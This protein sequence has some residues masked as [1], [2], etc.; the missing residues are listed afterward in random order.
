MFFKIKNLSKN[1]FLA[2]TFAVLGFG[3]TSCSQA[4]ENV[5]QPQIQKND[6]ELVSETK[7][8]KFVRVPSGEILLTL[9]T[10]IY[11]TLLKDVIKQHGNTLLDKIKNT[12]DLKTGSMTMQARKSKEFQEW[13]KASK[14]LATYS[15]SYSGTINGIGYQTV[16]LGNMLGTTFQNKTLTSFNFNINPYNNVPPFTYGMH[17][18]YYYD[19]TRDCYQPIDYNTRIEGFWINS[20]IY[21]SGFATNVYYQAHL[22]NIGW[23]SMYSAPEFVG[24][25]YESRRLEALKIWMIVL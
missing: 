8:F 7:E 6:A 23:T 4:E 13:Q 3:I 2:A 21:T 19:Q 12:Y 22:Q 18:Q 25:R 1:L 9:D 11:P 5:V 17:V 24:T 10:A 15:I 20:N 16:G 14:I